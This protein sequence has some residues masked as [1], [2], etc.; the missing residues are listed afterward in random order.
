M[1]KIIFTEKETGNK[2]ELENVIEFTLKSDGIIEGTIFKNNE[3]KNFIS[4]STNRNVE[5]IEQNVNFF[6]E[7]II[8]PKYYYLD[9]HVNNENSSGHY[10][11]P[12]SK[13]FFQHLYNRLKNDSI[14]HIAINKY[15]R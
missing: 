10:V 3:V 7:D 11:Y 15:L 8:S 5:I 6:C 2:I 4:H 13:M 9:L 12:L 14:N 1:K